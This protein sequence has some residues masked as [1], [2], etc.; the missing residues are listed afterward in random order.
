MIRN[1]A[2]LSREL[3]KIMGFLKPKLRLRQYMTPPSIAAE[4]LWTAFMSRDIEGRRVFDLGCGTGML[5]IGA[6]LLGGDVTGF[7]L[8]PEAIEVAIENAQM[9][10]VHILVFEEDV[11]SVSDFCDTV[12]MNPPF[13]V[14]GGKNDKV[15]LEKAFKLA[16]R[17]YSIHTS[18]TRDWV[19]KF[20]KSN[21]FTAHLISVRE[22]PL[23]KQYEHHEQ[24]KGKQKVDLWFFSK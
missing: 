1:K 11:E 14:K 19:Q 18:Q 13:M 2:H 5:T 9:L 3:G 23:P 21:G 17:V 20:A 22:F 15:F 8:D 10:N 12:V 6:S 16:N 24:L 4:L 7:D